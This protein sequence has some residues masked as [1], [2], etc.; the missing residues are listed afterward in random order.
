MDS[1]FNFTTSLQYSIKSLTKQ[2]MAFK[3]GDKYVQM[4]KDHQKEVCSYEK[5]IKELKAELEDAHTQIVKNRNQ[6]FQ[7]YEDLLKEKEQL[8][9]D[10]EKKLRK[11]EERAIKAEA[12]RDEA[13]NKVT[14]Q[15]HMLY[16]LGTEL[17]EEKEKNLKLTAQ[18][19]HDYEN[20]SIP[21]S[22]AVIKK[23][24]ITNNREKTGRKPGGQP[25]HPAHGRKKQTPTEPPILLPPPQEVLNDPDFKKTSKTIVKQIVGIK[26]ILKVKEYHA[27]VYHN[28]K[29]GE[30]V[31]A[32]FPEGVVDDVNYDGSIRAFL[33]L[34]NN[35]CCAS[36]DKSRKFLSDLTYGK[37]NISKGMVNKLSKE[38][39]KK[40]Q[41]EQQALFQALL[42]SPVLHTDCTYARE[43]GNNAFVFVCTT[44]NG[45][46]VLCPSQERA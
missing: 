1:S 2:L 16:K 9:A 38:F 26:V 29:T 19:N 27:D 32:A 35:D 42:A 13:L 28:S 21:S 17:E 12:Q 24:K 43:N 4:A 46:D 5:T 14:E 45:D 3:S 18:V 39:A 23:K 20:S 8:K 22:K 34:L 25:G 33:F 6:W 36:I 40:T 11:M 44:P 31:H 7:V 41:K 30:Y 10:Y 15:R 37:L